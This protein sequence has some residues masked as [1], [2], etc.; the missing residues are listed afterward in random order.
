MQALPTGARATVAEPAAVVRVWIEDGQGSIARGMVQ[1]ITENRVLVRLAEAASMHS[2]DDV[3]VRLSFDRDSPTLGAAA[4]VVRIRA[5][6]ENSEC[7][8]EWTNSGPERALLA[9][10]IATLD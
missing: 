10:R 7:E 9:S 2:G 3:S 1:A 4:R 8:L 6:G 5:N